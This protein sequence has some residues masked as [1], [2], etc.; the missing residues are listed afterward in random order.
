MSVIGLQCYNAVRK[1]CEETVHVAQVYV[2]A[3]FAFQFLR[4]QLAKQSV[5]ATVAAP[6][7]FPLPVFDVRAAGVCDPALEIERSVRVLV[8]I[9]VELGFLADSFNYG[10][11]NF[12][13]GICLL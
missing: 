13:F 4:E 10:F 6:S 11:L 8:H 9:P 2:R 7:K 12:C 5:I 1:L 3:S